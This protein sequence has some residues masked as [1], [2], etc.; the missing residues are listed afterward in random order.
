VPKLRHRWPLLIVLAAALWLTGARGQDLDAGKT[1][2]QLFAQDCAG[3]HRSPQGLAKNMNS[4]SLVG[5]LR[6]HYTS[7]SNSAGVVAAYVLAN[8]GNPRTDKQKARP[9][10]DQA[11]QSGQAQDR[12]RL[13]RPTEPTAAPPSGEPGA[14]HPVPSRKQQEKLARPGEPS[15]AQPGRPPRKSRRP[16]EPA[17]APAPEPAAAQAIA[18]AVPEPAPGAGGEAAP[19]AARQSATAAQPSFA[20]PLP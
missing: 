19:M 2:P 12:S 15:A 5:F 3:C 1:G 7:S 11:K 17:E 10:E 18:P 8:A 6:Q 9:G 20:E 13:A 4:G 16:G 14:V